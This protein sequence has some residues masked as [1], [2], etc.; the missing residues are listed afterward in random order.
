M[1]NIQNVFVIKTDIQ[2]KEF[3]L[4]TSWYKSE[5]EFFQIQ[6]FG[7]GCCWSGRFTTA[8]ADKYRE[9]VD[10]NITNYRNNVFT[11]LTKDNND[12]VYNF[13]SV[14]NENNSRKF[15][16]KKRFEG[17]T[18]LIVHGIVELDLDT[19]ASSNDLIDFLL[20][21]NDQLMNQIEETKHN[22]EKLAQY[23]DKT[24][25][26]LEDFT[27]MKVEWEAT[28]YSKFRDLLNT[29]K[30]RIQ[31]LEELLKN[32]TEGCDTD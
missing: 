29:K 21:K 1:D 5:N 9:L 25:K 19:E 24:K 32:K 30:K 18:A 7:D 20:H 15:C 22:S 26:D 12:Y 13:S 2:E 23:L 6:I 10:E 27:S 17:S 16:W 14:N 3:Y 8:F 4:K 28:L 11:A 31:L